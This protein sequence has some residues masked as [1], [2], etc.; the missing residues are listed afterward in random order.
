MTSACTVTT[1]STGAASPGC[2]SA[3]ANPNE[4]DVG[5]EP[6]G[7]AL[8]LGE[9]AVAP[10]GSFVIFKG[11]KSLLVG[12]PGDARVDELSLQFPTKLAFSKQR[13]VVYVGALDGRIHSI[14]VAQN[15]ELWSAPV[16]TGAFGDSLFEVSKADDRLLVATGAHLTILDAATGA[17]VSEQDLA[18][19][20]VDLRILPDDERAL[21]V[22]RE[23]WPQDAATPTTEVSVVAIGDGKAS[24]FQVPNC[25]SPLAVTPDG[26]KAFLSPTFCNKDPISLLELSPGKEGWVKNLPGFGPLALGPRGA[27]AVAFLD[28]QHLDETL[29]DDPAQIPPHGPNDPRYYL[30]TLDTASLDYEFSLWGNTLPRYQLT[31]DGR[32]LLVDTEFGGNVR[33]FDTATR[34]LRD[35]TGASVSLDDFVVTDDSKHVYA[36]G[37]FG[38]GLVDLDVA[39]GT[40]TELSTDGLVPSNINVSPDEQTL[41][42]RVNPS[43]VCIYDLASPSCRDLFMKMAPVQPTL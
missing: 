36:L 11:A 19:S 32:S 41:Y 24:S 31:P 10:T 26:S 34:K 15:R 22:T 4:H 6:G 20:I 17:I 40:A 30:M 27:T 21:V 29:F 33:I 35:V 14:D 1:L 38:L 8:D 9:I 7:V 39:K 28:A 12:W 5:D 43:T 37:A 2:G 18:S 42:L 16:S 25:A 13:T 23:S 3:G